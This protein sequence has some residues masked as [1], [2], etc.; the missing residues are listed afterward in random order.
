MT[1]SMIER[2]AR[3]ISRAR[4]LNGGDESDD[5]WDRA[6]PAMQI[7]YLEEA[8][9]AIEAMRE[10]TP[11]MAALHDD[12]EDIRIVWNSLLDAALEGPIIK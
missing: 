7:Q 10:M 5:G 3:A 12:D 8:R 4:F 1:D 2:V 11:A 6:T 9:A